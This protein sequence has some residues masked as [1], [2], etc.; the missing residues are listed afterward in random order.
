M[1]RYRHIVRVVGVEEWRKEHSR[2]GT[3]SLIIPDWDPDKV[4]FHPLSAIHEDLPDYE[5]KPGDRLVAVVDTEVVKA[6]ELDIADFDL[7]E[8]AEP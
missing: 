4:V 2:G 5:P 3:V 1:A 6:N 7:L 8:I